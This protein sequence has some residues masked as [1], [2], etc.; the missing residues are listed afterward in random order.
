MFVVKD[1][2]NLQLFKNIKEYTRE[3]N[4][5]YVMFVVKDLVIQVKFDMLH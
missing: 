4:P 2:L 3:K 1:F 5:T